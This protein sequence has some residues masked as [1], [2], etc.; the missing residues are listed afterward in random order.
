VS[1]PDNFIND[2]LYKAFDEVY[3]NE[4]LKFDLVVDK[5]TLYSDLDGK[6]G[7]LDE[8]GRKLFLFDTVV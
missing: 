1:V 2:E 5:K 4:Y 7:E 3:E 8:A 6:A